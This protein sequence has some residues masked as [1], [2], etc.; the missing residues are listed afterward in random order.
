MVDANANR[1]MVLFAD[2]NK[3]Y[4][5]I[6]YLLQLSSIFLIGIFQMLEGTSRVNI[7]AWVYTYLLTV[8]CCYVSH[9][10]RKVN[11]CHYWLEITIGFQTG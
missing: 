9:M 3:W 2:I 6:L 8:L 11:V 10:G 7:V 4:E 5:L 1:S